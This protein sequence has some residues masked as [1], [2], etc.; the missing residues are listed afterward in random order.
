[1]GDTELAD[2]E[3]TE[4]EVGEV[5]K[6]ELVGVEVE[7]LGDDELLRGVELLREVELL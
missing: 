2:V 1:M 4:D 3:L 7:L 5:V 6:I